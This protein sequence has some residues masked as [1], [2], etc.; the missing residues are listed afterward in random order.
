[1]EQMGINVGHSVH[2]ALKNPFCKGKISLLSG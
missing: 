1:M 2:Y